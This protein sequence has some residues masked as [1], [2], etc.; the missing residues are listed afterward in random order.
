SSSSQAL[1]QELA[2]LLVRAGQEC[3]GSTETCLPTLTDIRRKVW[4]QV[5]A[6]TA[7]TGDAVLPGG[8]DSE[9]VIG[10]SVCSSGTS[11]FYRHVWK[12]GGHSLFEKLQAISDHYEQKS[13]LSFCRKFVYVP[14]SKKKTFTFVRQPISRFI[15]AYAEIEKR[16]RLGHH[17]YKVLNQSLSAYPAGSSGRAA[18]FFRQYLKD[19][20]RQD[21]HL[22][23]QM[24]FF[25]P[26]GGCAVPYDFV[27]KVESM[28]EDWARLMLP[29]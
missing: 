10:E 25:T 17:E 22:R 5:Q 29:I 2:H 20:I 16:V 15:S 11:M 28:E 6:L 12:A 23:S 27:G 8:F 3:L 18:E 1:A 19:G 14:T 9:Q 4:P 21:G 24:E 26:V 7:W 13:Y